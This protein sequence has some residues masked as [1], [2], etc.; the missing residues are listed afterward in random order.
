MRLSD[1]AGRHPP[2]TFR[3]PMRGYESA[4]LATGDVVTAVPNPHEGL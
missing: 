1:R 4:A 2:D 3:I